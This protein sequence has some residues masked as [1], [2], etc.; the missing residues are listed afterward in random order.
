[1]GAGGARIAALR[2]ASTKREQRVSKTCQMTGAFLHRSA[3]WRTVAARRGAKG[4]SIF[5]G[6]DGAAG[7]D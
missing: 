5:G 4:L 6:L 3:L 1:M 2:M 7:G